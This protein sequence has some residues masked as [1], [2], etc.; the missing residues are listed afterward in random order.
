MIITRSY[1]SA[2]ESPA[3]SNLL[4]VNGSK[5]PSNIRMAPVTPPGYAMIG[6][7]K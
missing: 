7:T 5:H 1:Q 3:S 2:M 6:N 4:D